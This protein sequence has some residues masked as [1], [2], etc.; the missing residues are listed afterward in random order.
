MLSWRN[1][2]LDCSCDDGCEGCN[3]CSNGVGLAIYL[4]DLERPIAAT[5]LSRVLGRYELAL[6]SGKM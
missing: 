5:L 3:C 4:S 1:S 6:G 2:S